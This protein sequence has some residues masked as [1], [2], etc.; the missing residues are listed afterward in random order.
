MARLANA[1]LSLLLTG[2]VVGAL[3][4]AIIPAVTG[5]K[6]VTITANSMQQTLPLGTLV[7]IQPQ[8]AYALGDVVTFPWN[9]TFVTHQLVGHPENP[10]NGDTDTTRWNTKGT[11]NT[12][13]DPWT[14]RT[15][16]IKGKVLYALPY[17]GTVLKVLSFPVVWA[18][19]GLVALGLYLLTR[20]TSMKDK[21]TRDLIEEDARARDEVKAAAVVK[22][23]EEPAMHD[24]GKDEPDDVEP[25]AV[26]TSGENLQPA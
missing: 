25:G 3:A 11:N 9:G 5:T 4:L 2:L 1:G 10:T 12:Q 6:A 23:S 19:L 16:D 26:P 22:A 18:F 21:D 8:E 7:Y 20:S 14:I 13:P 24:D 15:E 17:G